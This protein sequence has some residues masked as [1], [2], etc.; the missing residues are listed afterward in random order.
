MLY[1]TNSLFSFNTLI[2]LILL[3]ILI[4][5]SSKLNDV[6]SSIRYLLLSF[7][8]SFCIFEIIKKKYCFIINKKIVIFLL[9]YLVIQSLSFTYAKNTSVIYP[10]LIIT[11]SLLGGIIILPTILINKKKL[12]NIILKTIVI[13]CFL[14]NT[15]GI[16]DFYSISGNLNLPNNDSYLISSLF[17]NKNI[18]SSALAICMPLILKLFLVENGKWKMFSYVSININFC[19]ILLLETRS[20]YIIIFIYAIILFSYFL[21]LILFKKQKLNSIISNNLKWIIISL[22]IFSLFLILKFTPLNNDSFLKNESSNST[23]SVKKIA[24]INERIFL[25]NNSLLLI[26]EHFFLGVGTGNWKVE[27][28]KNGITNSAASFG[29]VVFKYPHNDFIGVFAENGILGFS[30]YLIFYLI[31]IFQL[32][33]AIRNKHNITNNLIYLSG[34]LGY[35]I[36][37][38]FEYPKNRPEHLTLLIIYISFHISS[39][40]NYLKNNTIIKNATSFK[41]FISFI[42]ISCLIYN[43]GSVR[44]N[45]YYQKINENR[46]RENWQ[47]VILYSNK[48]N[49]NHYDSDVNCIPLMWHKGIANFSVGNYKLAKKQFWLAYKSYP[50]NLHVL[51]NLGST[52]SLLNNNDSAIVFYKKALILS[53]E[54]DEARI[55]FCILLYQTNETN[56]CL[57]EL[58]KITDKTI[59]SKNLEFCK[60]I[61]KIEL[62]KNCT[63]L[64]S[65]IKELS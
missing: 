41:Y 24:S 11:I 13:V 49:P 63:D 27:F 22:S 16:Y 45:Y 12:G 61:I 47:N 10:E 44:A 62:H 8:I 5:Q 33:K 59:I 40:N 30:F 19:L 65:V 38:Q 53:N 64:D 17:G 4:S 26:K 51:N 15:I 25:W 35:L 1:K 55:N 42:L 28:N 21:S 37:C 23:Y 6:T 2:N 58:K 18:Y 54:F 46:I 3:C 52:Y 39:Q 34:I 20:V 48:I 14:W 29:N 7:F 57:N 50:Y 9:M 31:I 32:G 43:F 60:E 56:K 36:Y